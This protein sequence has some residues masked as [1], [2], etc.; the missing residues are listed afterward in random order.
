MFCVHCGHELSDAAT[1]CPYCGHDLEYVSDE[2]AVDEDAASENSIEFDE[3][4][5]QEQEDKQSY[6]STVC[7]N[8]SPLLTLQMSLR[9]LIGKR[10]TRRIVV[11]ALI[12]VLLAIVGTQIYYRSFFDPSKAK[13]TGSYSLNLGDSIRLD[14]INATLEFISA[15][16]ES[17]NYDTLTLDLVWTAKLY[18]D[19]ELNRSGERQYNL[20][21]DWISNV[22][23]NDNQAISSM[24]TW[25]SY[26]QNYIEY[27]TYATV[28]YTENVNSLKY[29][30]NNHL[31]IVLNYDFPFSA[32]QILMEK[33]DLYLENGEYDLAIDVYNAIGTNEA[34]RKVEGINCIDY[35]EKVT[36]ALNR[37]Q[38][39]LFMSL[40]GFIYSYEY[41][42]ATYTYYQILELPEYFDSI[43]SLYGIEYGSEVLNEDGLATKAEDLYF[44]YF[45]PAGYIG[46]TSSVLVYKSTGELIGEF[47]Y[48]G[49]SYIESNGSIS[50]D[51]GGENSALVYFVEHCNTEYFSKADLTGFDADMCRI[52]RNGIYARSGRIFQDEALQEYFSQYSWYIPVIAA[53]A[54]TEDMLNDYQIANR[55]LIIQYET[56][57]GYR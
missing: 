32:E 30:I 4:N 17:V 27:T 48:S 19:K 2:N 49:K 16:I 42:P 24:S 25:V 45:Y 57:Q 1:Y 26:E 37:S 13:E 46:I 55:D 34:L 43:S 35:A 38:E 14:S 10:T 6:T 29:E 23:Y 44:D 52:A 21:R 12:I 54:F 33:A 5:Y 39:T 31:N 53:D 20:C 3:Y 15:N 40:V 41:D 56:E 9:L 8:T 11:A 28:S 7:N 47:S 36:N 50:E 22:Y 18:S 51:V